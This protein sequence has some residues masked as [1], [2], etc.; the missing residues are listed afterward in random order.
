MHLKA[1]A[2]ALHFAEQPFGFVH[3]LIYVLVVS[4]QP[5]RKST[6]KGRRLHRSN[7]I[8]SRLMRGGWCSFK[9]VCHPAFSLIRL[10]G[11]K[12]ARLLLLNSNVVVTQVYG[13]V[14]NPISH[15]RSPALHNAAL[16]AC[17]LDGVYLPLLV[18]DMDAFLAASA[19]VE[20]VGVSVT[21]PHKVSSSIFMLSVCLMC[22]FCVHSGGLPVTSHSILM[23]CASA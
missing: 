15:S 13:V 22:H 18:E 1:A 9:L 12:A 7:H 4:T 21:I 3:D 20:F 19:V 23:P 8:R 6:Q 2:P 16:A 17:D 11:F 5:G 10:P 14:G